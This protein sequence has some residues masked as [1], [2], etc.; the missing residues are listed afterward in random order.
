[1]TPAFRSGLAALLSGDLLTGKVAI[2][3]GAGR[4]IG[5]GIARKLAQE[6]AVVVC[7]DINLSDASN[8]ASS[9]SPAGLGVRLDV[10]TASECDAAVM[11]THERYRPRLYCHGY[12]PRHSRRDPRTASREDSAGAHGPAL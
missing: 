3:T 4:G 7:A 5:E 2:V 6:G 10:T 9:L 1:M 8:V 12:D 11:N